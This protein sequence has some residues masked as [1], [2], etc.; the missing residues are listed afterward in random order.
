MALKNTWELL[1]EAFRHWRE[2]DPFRLGAALAYYT[3]F[4][5]APLVPKEHAEL[6]TEEA[7]ARPARAGR[8]AARAHSGAP[9]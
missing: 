6:V 4:S 1:K 9:T 5:L 7:R 3:V 8:P 2:D